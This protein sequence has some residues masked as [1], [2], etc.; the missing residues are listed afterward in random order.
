MI[1]LRITSRIKGTMD[2]VAPTPFPIILLPGHTAEIRR[3]PEGNVHA[4]IF[5]RGDQLYRD[6]DLPVILEYLES[7][8]LHRE[9]WMLNGLRGREGD[10]PYQVTYYPSGE[11]EGESW[12]INGTYGREGGKPIHVEYYETGERRY[13]SLSTARAICHAIYYYKSGQI[14]IE[15]WLKNG[16]LNR[17]GDE[18]AR[19]EYYPTGNPKIEE[20]YREG[21]HYRN[22]Y[23]PTTIEYYP[24]G[25]I[26]KEIL[27]DDG[28][29]IYVK[30]YELELLT[31]GIR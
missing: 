3:Y 16:F 24:T 19:T 10:K 8:G 6:E 30:E 11:I 15:T 7:G 1:H 5:S 13:E 26:R 23:K 9:T 28:L 22:G 17:T 27:E 4:I 21:S 14:E 12:S 31:K 25:Q 29:V 20:W 18:P 2:I